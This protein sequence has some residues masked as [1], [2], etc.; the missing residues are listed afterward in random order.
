MRIRAD[1]TV[2]LSGVIVG[3][4]VTS[5]DGFS[6][7]ES[8]DT[9][10]DAGSFAGR[11]EHISYARA[12]QSFTALIGMHQAHERLWNAFLSKSNLGDYDPGSN[13]NPANLL[14]KGVSYLPDDAEITL[15][16]TKQEFID[17]RMTSWEGLAIGGINHRTA[18]EMWME[19]QLAEI[20]RLKLALLNTEEN[21]DP[22]AVQLLEEQQEVHQKAVIAY[23]DAPGAD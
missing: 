17:L 9:S 18:V 15:T 1:Y 10:S 22:G 12:H 7:Q 19:F 5:V 3:I 23:L 4:L 16:L 8:S 11:T 2:L 6:Q 13:H 14:G 20:A 21:P